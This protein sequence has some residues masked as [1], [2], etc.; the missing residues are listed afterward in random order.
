M[1][2]RVE[3]NVTGTTRTP[4]HAAGVTM[5]RHAVSAICHRR[6]LIRAHDVVFME[7]MSISTARFHVW[8]YGYPMPQAELGARS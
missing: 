8:F 3:R 4:G 1:A 2:S 6:R 7:P 5:P